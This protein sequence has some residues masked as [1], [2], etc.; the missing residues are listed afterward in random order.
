MRITIL[1]DEQL[2]VTSKGR[3]EAV[4]GPEQVG[5]RIVTAIN[6]GNDTLGKL[7][8]HFKSGGLSPRSKLAIS[9]RAGTEKHIR[10]YLSWL[11]RNGWITR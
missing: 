6:G 2:L 7:T 5:S 11:I 9:G 1:P 10:D 3:S 8:D 4:A